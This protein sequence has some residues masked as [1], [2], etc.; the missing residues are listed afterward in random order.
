MN[1]LPVQLI[2]LSQVDKLN[3]SGRGGKEKIISLLL[4]NWKR[5]HSPLYDY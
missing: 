2:E 5:S 4:P 1:I 3:I